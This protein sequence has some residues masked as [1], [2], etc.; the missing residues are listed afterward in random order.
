MYK[1]LLTLIINTYVHEEQTDKMYGTRKQ[2]Y[3]CYIAE[4]FLI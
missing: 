3:V 4:L 1:Y 2:H